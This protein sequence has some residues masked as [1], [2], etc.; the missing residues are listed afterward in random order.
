MEWGVDSVDSRTQLQ[1][2]RGGIRHRWPVPLRDSPASWP[3]VA[4]TVGCLQVAATSWGRK[5]GAEQSQC[6][7]LLT[8]VTTFLT[9]ASTMIPPQG[10]TGLLHPRRSRHVGPEPVT[11]TAAPRWT[12]KSSRARTQVRTLD[13]AEMRE[14]RLGSSTKLGGW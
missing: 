1:T 11:Y 5:G 12:A 10:R 8:F 9:F 14:A 3:A 7:L 6:H 4:V 2:Q 13:Q